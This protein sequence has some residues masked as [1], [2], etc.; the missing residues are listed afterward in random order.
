MQEIPRPEY[1]QPQFQRELW[2]NLNGEWQFE[3]DDPDVGL[4]QH[5]ECGQK[6]FTRRILVPF[7]FESPMSGI[8]DQQFHTPIWYRRPFILDERWNGKRVL[9]RF[10]AVDYRATVWINGRMG[11]DHEGGHTP[12]AMD[13]SRFLHPGENWI[14]VRVEDP[15]DQYIPRGK[16]YWEQE[17]RGIFYART[18]G[19]WQSVWLE[20]VGSS[21][22]DKVRI[23]TTNEGAVIFDANIARW[24]IGLEFAAIISYNGQV[25][26][27]SIGHCEDYLSTV[28]A[29]IRNPKLWWPHAPHLYDVTFELRAGDVVLDRVNSYFGFRTVGTEGKDVL[30]NGKRMYL[31]FVLDQGYWP[32]SNM[33]P[34]SD[35]AIQYD[36][37]MTKEFGFNGARKHQKIEDPRYYYWADKMGIL[38]S[39]EMANAY[40]F[41]EGSVSRVTREW[42]EAVERD[43]NHPSVIIWVPLNE[44]WGVPNLRDSRQQNH[45][46]AM[47]ALT[48]SLDSTRLVID[49]DGWE[50]TEMTDLFAIHDYTTDG[51]LFYERFKDVGK[52]GVPIPGFATPVL[53][54]GCSYNGA[55]VYLS[56][57]GGIA[58]NPPD[59]PIPVNSWGYSG[60]ENTAEEALTR[61]SGL[62]EAISRIP[63]FC[64]VCYTQ[65]VDVEQ[66]INGLLTY[67]RRLKYDPAE[68]RKINA[69]LP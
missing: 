1:P 55:P 27:T 51:A 38:V 42:I 56:E 67:D 19:I 2:M 35:E 3:F 8:G 61:M 33:T 32:Q 15:P 13:V 18:S 14:T 39:A 17:S 40:Q 7:C 6:D 22:L 47:Y 25:L 68:M 50:H 10:G 46:R 43:Y 4:D 9:L 21:Y 36:I 48:R 31:K 54:Q 53:V 20:S 44:S 65:L 63:G 60:V 34:P 49:N 58:F 24:T 59:N 62:Y 45:L 23:N 69:L 52:P 29:T 28:A 5:W 66:E 37:R 26:T 11:G 41:D 57:F 12:F 30:L 16:Q 64:G